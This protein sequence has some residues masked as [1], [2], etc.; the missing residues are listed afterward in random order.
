MLVFA[1]PAGIEQFFEELSDISARGA[2]NPAKL[3][4]LASPYGITFPP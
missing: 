4:Q 2:P 3:T 1:Q